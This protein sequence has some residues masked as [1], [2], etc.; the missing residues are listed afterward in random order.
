[1]K[2]R[3][4]KTLLLIICAIVLSYKIQAKENKIGS[5]ISLGSKGIGIGLNY[6]KYNLYS[7]YF[8]EYYEEP[9]NNIYVYYHFPELIL[10]KSIYEEEIGNVYLGLG[11][12]DRTYK[13][14]YFFNG[15]FNTYHYN[16][17]TPIGIQIRPFK[18]NDKFSFILESGVQFEHGFLEMHPLISGY[19]WQ[20]G[21]ARAVV[22]IRY[23]LGKRIR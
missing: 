13:Q 1:M 19:D 21:L 8:Y 16:I 10:T 20:I 22:D 4:I 23:R 2:Q 12:S 11:F 7:R 9:W 5:F 17:S 3:K 6:K 14:K 18:K 15:T